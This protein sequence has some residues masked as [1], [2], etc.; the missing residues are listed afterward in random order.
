[1]GQRES[2]LDDIKVRH[3]VYEDRMSKAREDPRLVETLKTMVSKLEG[4]IAN[5]ADR[6]I[7]SESVRIVGAAN[8]ISLQAKHTSQ[9][10]TQTTGMEQSICS[11]KSCVA[12]PLVQLQLNAWSWAEIVGQPFDNF[13]ETYSFLA[14][15]RP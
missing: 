3:S 11:S 15:D 6:D 13:P 1:M 7:P 2:K 8:K 9:A 12:T 10:D 14:N 5:A 4:L